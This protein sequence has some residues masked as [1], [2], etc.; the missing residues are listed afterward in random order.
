MIK[1]NIRNLESKT[2]TVFTELGYS[3]F[4]IRKTLIIART[5]TRLH[6]KQDEKY[7]RRDIAASYAK[8]QESRYKNNEIGKGTFIMYRNAVDYLTQ[9]SETGTFTPKQNEQ[10]LYLPDAF[11]AVLSNLLSNKEWSPKHRKHQRNHA[12]TFFKWLHSCGHK[13]LS[14]VDEQVVREYLI[15]CSAKMVGYSLDNTRRALKKLFIFLSE[16]GVLSEQMN[17]LFLFN[18]KIERK[19]K[20]FMPQNEIAAVLDAIDQKTVRGKRDYAL[21][22]LA[23]VTG[24]RAIDIVELTLDEICWRNGEMKIIQEK[25]GSSLALPLTTDAGK[26]IED[27]IL[28]AR[29]TSDSN[30]VFLS[31]RVPFGAMYRLTP[32]KI[33]QAYC[34]KA[35]LTTR[36]GFHTLRRGIAT[37]MV[38]SGVSVV[39]VAQALGHKTINPTKQYISLDS[40]NL[41]ECALDFSGI[42]IGGDVL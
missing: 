31:T 34:V 7:F 13:D 36:W 20:P 18:V 11:E 2:L 22:L 33:L 40:Q 24:L 9:I 5:L 14:R 17:K 28:N 32:I 38:T 26:A 29:P 21:I 19:I 41:K 3:E 1:D 30:R 25:T 35:G 16:D 10:K 12:Q 8:H 27:Y 37:S 6:I 42:K 15:D 4:S 39:T 23:A